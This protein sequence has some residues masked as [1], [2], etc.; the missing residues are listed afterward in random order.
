MSTNITTLD[1][2]LTMPP[3]ALA[4][5]T[6]S[7][8]ELAAA[9]DIALERVL[10]VINGEHYAGAERVQDL[11][12]QGLRPLGYEVNFVCL[13]AGSFAA[14][15]GSRSAPLFQYN[16]AGRFDIRPAAAVARLRALAQRADHS[17]PHAA[18]RARRQVGGGLDRRVAGASC[19]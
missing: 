18:G 7:Q 5:L 1:S 13:K 11:L 14:E 15:R 16:M 17:H 9:S 4:P 8:A 2:L 19:A 3:P 12:A 6:P 10:H